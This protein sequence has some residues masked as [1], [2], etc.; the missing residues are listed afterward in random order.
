M[1]AVRLARIAHKCFAFGKWGDS[2]TDK[3]YQ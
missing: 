1:G 2:P 3:E